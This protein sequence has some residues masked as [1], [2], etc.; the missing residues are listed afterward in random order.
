MRQNSPARNR[1][2]E[3]LEKSGALPPAPVQDEPLI[4]DPID[5]ESECL[6]G[7][8]ETDHLVD[9]PLPAH[10]IKLFA[11]RGTKTPDRSFAQALRKV[12]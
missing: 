11:P 4:E 9:E 6:D 1:Y 8:I 12:G 3:F 5:D 2:L 10:E 7:G